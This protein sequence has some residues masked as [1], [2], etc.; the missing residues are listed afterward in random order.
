MY[1]TTSLSFILT[2]IVYGLA[3]I[4][5]NSRFYAYHKLRRIKYIMIKNKWIGNFLV[6]QWLRL[7]TFIAISGLRFWSL[8]G[9]LR[10]Y[11][12]R[13]AAKNE[14]KQKTQVN[15]FAINSSVFTENFY[16]MQL[17]QCHMLRK[18]QIGPCDGSQ[19]ENLLLVCNFN[20]YLIKFA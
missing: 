6:V 17:K 11:K 16:L 2:S 3:K 15:N 10:S 7:G 14:N 12:S 20:L 18:K 5:R 13:G 4:Q 9:E 1:Q 8:V 19:I